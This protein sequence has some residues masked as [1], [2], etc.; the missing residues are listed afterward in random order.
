MGTQLLLRRINILL[1]CSLL[2]LAV[3]AQEKEI[4]KVDDY[5]AKAKEASDKSKKTDLYN[6][7]A[8]LIMSARLDKS[9]NMKIG[10][11]YLEE[12]DVTNAI[13][14]YMRCE[15]E[16]KNEGYKKAGDKTIEQ[17]FDDPKMEDKTMRKAIS[18]YS[19]AKAAE[20][21]Y[22]AV[23]DAYYERGKDFRM[24]AAEFYGTGKAVNKIERIAGEYMDE[25][26]LHAAADVYMK[27]D[28]EEGYKKAGDLFYSVNDFNN[29]YS[30]YEKGGVTEGIKKYADKLYADGLKVDGDALYYKLAEIYTTKEDKESLARLARLAEEKSNYTMAASIYEQAGEAVNANKAK[31]YSHLVSLDFE[32]AEKAFKDL[33]DLE[34]AEGISKNMKYLVALRDVA[35][36][37]EEVKSFEPYV[38]YSEDPETKE[39]IPNKTD[40]AD[41]HAY[42]KGVASNIVER[43]YMISSNVQNIK[44]PILKKVMINTFKQFGAVR[45]VLDDNF[46]KKLQKEKATA[47]DVIL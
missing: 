38:A 47:R 2:T 1:I 8:Q 7:A 34:T 28:N 46:N 17:A 24:K 3:N 29:A 30:A 39:R 9:H 36:Y 32:T 41:F 5:I 43:C 23:G 11:A 10:D 26:N 45:N 4:A 12:G 22:E 44:D 37:F 18:Y 35:D 14:Y 42:Y 16:D 25:K 20:E 15:T 27:L 21:G 19:K 13:R 6:K 31:A 40:L 33:G